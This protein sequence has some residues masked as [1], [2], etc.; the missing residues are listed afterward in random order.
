MKDGNKEIGKINLKGSDFGNRKHA[1]SHLFRTQLAKYNKGVV[2]EQ[3]KQILTE[4]PRAQI[5]KQILKQSPPAQTIIITSNSFF[6][7]LIGLMIMNMLKNCKQ[8]WKKEVTKPG[9]NVLMW[10]DLATLTGNMNG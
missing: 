6:V 3:P 1:M 2:L 9:S 4:I 7:Y 8:L 10:Q 5:L